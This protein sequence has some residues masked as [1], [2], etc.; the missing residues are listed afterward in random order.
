M[1]DFLF[2]PVA[3]KVNRALQNFTTSKNVFVLFVN[4]RSLSYFGDNL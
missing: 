2:V 1:R 3:Q 4:Q